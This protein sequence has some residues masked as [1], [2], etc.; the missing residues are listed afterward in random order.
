MSYTLKQIRGYT[1]SISDDVDHVSTLISTTLCVA[2][3]EG[4]LKDIHNEQTIISHAL[5]RYDNA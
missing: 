5:S 1:G 2:H 3:N 4:L